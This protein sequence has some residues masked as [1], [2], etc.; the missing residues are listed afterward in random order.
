MPI[1]QKKRMLVPL[2]SPRQPSLLARVVI[3]VLRPLLLVLGFIFG[4]LYK[5]CF[6][7]LDRRLAR[8]NEQRFAD[9]IRTHLSF[10]FTEH[11]AQIIPN[12]GTPFPPGFD[13][14]YVTVIVGALRLRFVRGRGDFG[15]SVASEF[16]P[17]NWE[18]FRLVADNISEWDASQ[19]RRDPYSLETFADV[20]RP[21]L[22]RL[23]EALSKERL[24]ATLNRAVRTHNESVEEYAAKLRQAGVIPKFIEPSSR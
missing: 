1:D 21:R 19:R 13:G 14:A 4:N 17:Q 3:A 15:V 12:E 5:L 22:P 24:E 18:D 6:G 8:Q 9:E 20:L 2:R 10:L 11:G 23:Q 7:W 16:A